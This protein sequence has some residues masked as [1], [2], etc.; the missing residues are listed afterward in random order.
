ME[1][2]WMSVRGVHVTPMHVQ[3]QDL[4]DRP[5]DT[6]GRAAQGAHFIDRSPKHF[7]FVLN[8]M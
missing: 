2:G 3:V 1:G 6:C 8:F 4:A 5:A 7:D